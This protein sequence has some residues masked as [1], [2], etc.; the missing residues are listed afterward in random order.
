MTRIRSALT[1][2]AGALVAVGIAF[3]A[4]AEEI[5]G[6]HYVDKLK[7]SNHGSY[8]SAVELHYKNP[9]S[10]H[11]SSID[12]ASLKGEHNACLMSQN[13]NT[14]ID[15]GR[16]IEDDKKVAEGAQVWLIVYIGSGPTQ[17]CHKENAKF[18]YQ[19]G[20]NTTAKFS[21][22]GTTQNRN[23]CTYDGLTH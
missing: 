19:S 23:R 11:S 15:I 9:G 13:Q 21:T 20:S 8:N 3:A 14:I 6:D 10:D 16:S 22:A 7:Y 12:C 5:M 1:L 2:A 4:Q 18:Y 17:S